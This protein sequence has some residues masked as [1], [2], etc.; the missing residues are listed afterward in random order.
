MK[1]V[2]M[3]VKNT[4][5]TPQ[6]KN[7]TI[8]TNKSQIILRPD[9]EIGKSL[10]KQPKYE[11]VESK[12]LNKISIKDKFSGVISKIKEE[13]KKSKEIQYLN[14]RW[15]DVM[16][17]CKFINS[18]K[19]TF[20]LVNLK[21]ENYGF[22]C[23]IL[24]PDGYCIDDLDNKIPVIQNNVGCTFVLQ[25]FSNKRYANAK[26]I[27]IENC[28]K[29]PFEPIKV[30][31]Y[32][33]CSGVDEGGTPVIFNMNIEP[34]VLIAGATRM[35]KNGCIDH[36]I[37]SWI[38]YCSE[39]DIHLYLFQFAK[40]DLGKYAKCRQ[41]K[42]F[43]MS[44][45][46]KLLDVLNDINMEMKER[47]NVMSSMLNN[48]KGDNL[49]DYNKLNPNKKMP[50]IYIIIDEFMDIANSEGNKESARIKT[51]II[52]IL[53]SIAQYGGALGVNYIILHQKPEK[54]LMPTFL[55]N[56][57]NVRICFGFKDE[58]CGRIVLGE[59]RGKLVTTL[60][61]RKAY[62]VSSSGEGYL[63]T[64]NLRNKNGSS[65]I[66]NYIKSSMINKKDN[67]IH[68]MDEYKKARDK[69]GVKPNINNNSHDKSKSK[70]NNTQ[71]KQ[72]ISKIR[73]KMNEV[74]ESFKNTSNQENKIPKLPSESKNNLDNNSIQSTPKDNKNNN[75]LN[76]DKPIKNPNINSNFS[77]VN[78]SKPKSKE[79]I[80]RENIKKIPNFVPYEPPTSNAKII[81]ETDL[82]FK[83]SEKYKK[84]TINN[85]KEDD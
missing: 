53:Q 76:I 78:I 26:F 50:F 73:D 14:E 28:N 66:L 48:F 71:L 77:K 21:H 22:S 79:D 45:L 75:K 5:F 20:T 24:I 81:D 83:K 85:R 39:N 72:Q 9:K 11:I 52:S 2:F 64:T 17:N 19:K 38:Y 32:E 62:Y 25:K 57:S 80:I 56:Q 54:A 41:V 36:A 27:L 46:S 12:I 31:P 34:M 23:K 42:C 69:Q 8:D 67:N 37:P 1:L 33:V 40:G 44:D 70:D 35:G 84:N 6:D 51:H 82:I 29:I 55:K 61:P 74:N 47:M 7:R 10:L 43:S 58:V 63:Y 60:Q 18:F 16:F 15:L 65:R 4:K 30:E 59:D 13:C 3:H 68:Y 49:Y